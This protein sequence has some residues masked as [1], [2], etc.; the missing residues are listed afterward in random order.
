VPCQG[1]HARV[2][3]VFGAVVSTILFLVLT[4]CSELKD[5]DIALR[6]ER[7][8][9]GFEQLAKMAATKQLS[10]SERS[11]HSLECTDAEALPLFAGLN[12][13]DGVH[14]VQTESGMPRVAGGVY[15][16]MASYGLITT[17]SW[18]KGLLYATAKPSPIVTDTDEHEDVPRRYSA[19]SG[20]WYVFATP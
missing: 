17:N 2:L 18:S 20:N 15:F 19:L 5:R 1:V 11:D 6:F 16:V 7:D 12:K 14:S 10:C 8:R 4:A 13:R 3:A 9:G